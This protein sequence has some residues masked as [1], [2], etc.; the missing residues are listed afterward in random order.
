VSAA[1]TP[2]DH[3]FDIA[4]QQDGEALSDLPA[5]SSNL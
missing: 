4:E 3:A 2:F 1:K 5:W